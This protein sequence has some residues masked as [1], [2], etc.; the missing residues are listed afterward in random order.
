MSGIVWE[1]T[2]PKVL[3]G[4]TA[5]HR[6]KLIHT[7]FC[8]ISNNTTYGI[9]NVAR[10]SGANRSAINTLIV[11]HVALRTYYFGLIEKATKET[12]VRNSSFL[13]LNGGS[14]ISV[15]ANT[16]DPGS[17]PPY[18][19][20][21]VN[22]LSANNGLVHASTAD[23]VSID[24]SDYPQGQFT[25]DYTTCAN[26]PRQNFNPTS[27]AGYSNTGTTVTGLGNA[28]ACIPLTSNLA[29]SGLGGAPRRGQCDLAVPEWRQNLAE[30]VGD[31]Q[32][33]ELSGQQ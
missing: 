24:L 5:R 11:D 8:N 19:I 25:A 32:T 16:S 23:G 4:F 10:G 6:M 18:S 9:S 33:G 3:A 30:M 31:D 21:L 15:S 7:F 13:P 28:L 1:T 14:G 27:S 12:I 2:S 29:T 17:G 26:N 20:H 22:V